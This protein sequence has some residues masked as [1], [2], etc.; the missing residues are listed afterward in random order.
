MRLQI[1]LCIMAACLTLYIPNLWCAD[2]SR[3]N[4]GLSANGSDSSLLAQHWS[5]PDE[6][7]IEAIYEGKLD[8]ISLVALK[9]A[10][11]DRDL[12]VIAALAKRSASLHQRDESGQTVLHYAALARRPDALRFFLEQGANPNVRDNEGMLPINAAFMRPL[13]CFFWT[14]WQENNIKTFEHIK[15]IIKILIAEA[16]NDP[17]YV[18][19]NDRCEFSAMSDC[20]DTTLRQEMTRAYMDYNAAHTT[21]GSSAYY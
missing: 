18:Y 12:K 20:L 13:Y 6:Q 16:G 9:Q 7:L 14:N 19:K 11:Y 3:T 10:C 5:L 17:F 15:S 4:R 1:Y 2:S 8:S 21:Q